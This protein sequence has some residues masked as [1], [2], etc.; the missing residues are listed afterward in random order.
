MGWQTGP[1][2][3]DRLDKLSMLTAR[4]LRIVLHEKIQQSETQLRSLGGVEANL[5]GLYAQHARTE[6]EKMVNKSPNKEDL[7]KITESEGSTF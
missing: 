2:R 6:A 3:I 1:R 5:S 7:V 4:L